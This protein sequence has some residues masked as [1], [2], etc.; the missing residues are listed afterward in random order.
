M[1][2]ENWWDY[3]TTQNSDLD[4]LKNQVS[5]LQKTVAKLQ[6]QVKKLKTKQAKKSD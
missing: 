4:S 3:Y 5:D 2:T 6:K 1:Q